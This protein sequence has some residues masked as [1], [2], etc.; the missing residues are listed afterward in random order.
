MDCIKF[1]AIVT[2]THITHLILHR[3]LSSLSFHFL[4]FNF[5]SQYQRKTLEEI[6]NIL[7]LDILYVYCHCTYIFTKFRYI[8][9]FRAI[10]DYLKF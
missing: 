7:F 5:T 10:S 1:R 2:I 8:C 6:S 3:E 9:G 4:I